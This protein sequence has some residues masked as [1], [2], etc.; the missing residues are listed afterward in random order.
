[1]AVPRFVFLSRPVV[2]ETHEVIGGDVTWMLVSPNA[3]V[4]GRAADWFV[5]YE[6]CRTALTLLPTQRDLLKSVISVV[7]GQWHWRIEIDHVAVA[8]SS[9]SYLR[10]HEC[11]YNLQRFLDALPTAAIA[12]A[13]RIV[14]NKDAWR[15]EARS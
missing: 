5:D 3:R 11:D 2:D 7:A 12:P 8:V 4:L 14:R 6:T 13:V 9:R 15:I 1:M 10:Q